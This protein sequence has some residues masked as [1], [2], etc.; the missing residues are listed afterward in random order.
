[1][2]DDKGYYQSL[3]NVPL[4]RVYSY[5]EFDAPFWDAEA[6]IVVYPDGRVALEGSLMHTHMTP[7]NTGPT[8]TGSFNLTA[9]EGTAQAK[10]GLDVTFP[11]ELAS[12]F[13][14]N[15]TIAKMLAAY[16]NG[17][18]NLGMNSTLVLPSGN[19]GQYPYYPY[20]QWP[21]NATDGSA[22]LTYSGGLLNLEISGET[23]LP[24][25][26]KSQFPFN[27]TDFTVAG[28]YAANSLDGTITF[29]V[30]DDFT[31][32]DVNV[33]F[34]GTRTGL[35][36]NGSITVA[37][38]I[39]FSGF[40]AKNLTDL[41]QQI[42]TLRSAVLGESGIIWNMTKGQLNVTDFGANYSPLDS[43]GAKVT[44]EV[45]AQGD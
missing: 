42:D 8:A 4:S 20:G 36:L 39:Q 6:K 44:F 43:W 29:S 17:V 16:S 27:A 21:F 35:T 22:A 7:K 25:V 38:G 12:Q 40:V 32:D 13:P 41:E 15:S 24:P 34:T 10:A 1:M 37:F 14:F 28:T 23:T 19:L 3:S 9:N 31:F 33:D 18:L 26:V 30:L 45:K 5:T 11:Q 2:N